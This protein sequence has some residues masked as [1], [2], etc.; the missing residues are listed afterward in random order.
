MRGATTTTNCSTASVEEGELQ[1]VCVGA[2][3]QR[4]FSKMQQPN[5]RQVSRLLIR[6]GVA[7]HHFESPPALYEARL[8]R[9][10][11]NDL[12]D[13]FSGAFQNARRFQQRHNV[14]LRRAGRGVRR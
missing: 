14:D 1:V 2:I 7:E 3:H 8:E 12:I 6:I 5:A 9:R 11:R 10:V 13:E 4:R